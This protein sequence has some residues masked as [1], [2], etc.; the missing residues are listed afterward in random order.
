MVNNF[1]VPKQFHFLRWIATTTQ[2]DWFISIL[3]PIN[4]NSLSIN[5]CQE[6][7]RLFDDTGYKIIY[8]IK[9]ILI[10]LQPIK[11]RCHGWTVTAYTSFITVTIFVHISALLFLSTNLGNNEVSWWSAPYLFIQGILYCKNCTSNFQLSIC[12]YVAPHGTRIEST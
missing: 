8:Y 9:N 12:L 4:L 1:T 6:N 2:G 5:H 10:F 11:G 7:L 3:L